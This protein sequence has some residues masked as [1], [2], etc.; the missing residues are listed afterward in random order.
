MRPFAHLHN[1]TTYSVR[2]GV[3]KL[4]SM[5]AAAAADGQPAIA[6]TDHGSLGATW[7]MAGL[8]AKA[9]IKYIPGVELYGSSAS[10]RR[11]ASPRRR[12]VC[13]RR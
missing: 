11:R 1:H 8:C 7:K 3:Q 6:T 4:A 12:S 5:V 2:D 9:G 13:C 10:V